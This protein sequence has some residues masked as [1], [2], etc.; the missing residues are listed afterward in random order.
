MQ[1]RVTISSG[2]SNGGSPGVVALVV[3]AIVR[4]RPLLLRGGGHSSTYVIGTLGIGNSY[5]S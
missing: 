1:H 2:C 4:L 5:R 3:P